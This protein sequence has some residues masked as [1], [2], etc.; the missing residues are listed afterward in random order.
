MF[1]HA[2]TSPPQRTQCPHCEQGLTSGCSQ[3]PW[4]LQHHTSMVHQEHPHPQRTPQ[5]FGGSLCTDRSDTRQLSQ[6]CWA[7]R[8][9]K[10]GALCTFS[11]FMDL[12]ADLGTAAPR[13]LPGSPRAKQLSRQIRL[14]INS[15]PLTSPTAACLGTN[16]T[17]AKLQ[18]HKAPRKPRPTLPLQATL[19]SGS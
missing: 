16:I 12:G 7:G 2:Q 14:E 9:R 17:S 13:S 1:F 18:K 5:S 19:F 4:A 6:Q 8:S 11:T 15:R 3:G 10:E